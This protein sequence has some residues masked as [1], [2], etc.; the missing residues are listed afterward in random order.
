[1]NQCVQHFLYL[2]HIIGEAFE[3]VGI[4]EVQFVRED[5]L[6]LQFSGR[7]RR[8]LEEA[9]KLSVSTPSITLGDVGGDGYSCSS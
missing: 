9:G 8:E 3:V 5:Q 2:D 1:L 7:A 4:Q 6:I